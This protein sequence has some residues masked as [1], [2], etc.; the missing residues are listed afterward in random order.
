MIVAIAVI[1]HYLWMAF[2]LVGCAYVVF[3]KGFSGWWFL[4]AIL[5]ALGAN[6]TINSKG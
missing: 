4:L 2:C 1:L 3:W 5:L 6:V